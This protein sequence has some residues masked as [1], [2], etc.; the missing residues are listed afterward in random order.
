MTNNS[1]YNELETLRKQWRIEDIAWRVKMNRYDKW[2][3]R[4]VYVVAVYDFAAAFFVLAK[5]NWGLALINFICGLAMV[6]LAYNAQRNIRRREAEIAE[7]E[8]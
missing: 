2:Y 5:G 1:F 3:A 8:R 4:I 6:W 7:L